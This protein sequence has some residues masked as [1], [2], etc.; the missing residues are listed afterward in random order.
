MGGRRKPRR[1]DGVG[2]THN[3][4]IVIVTK[5]I[6]PAYRP[7]DESR[8]VNWSASPSVLPSDAMMM[9]SIKERRLKPRMPEVEQ[10]AACGLQEAVKTMDHVEY[11]LKH[12]SKSSN[13][14]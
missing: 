10:S 13:L 5:A 1:R 14:G 8:D 12:Y 9:A 6:A 7:T 4:D 2:R 11:D 3:F